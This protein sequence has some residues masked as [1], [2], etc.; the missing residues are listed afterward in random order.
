MD[1]QLLS[2]HELFTMAQRGDCEAISEIVLRFDP[3]IS[4]KCK[5]NGVVDEDI[6]QDTRIALFVELKKRYLL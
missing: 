5:I 3:L 2:I 6:I 1:Y 4:K